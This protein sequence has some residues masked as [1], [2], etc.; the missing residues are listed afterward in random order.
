[1]EGMATKQN[2]EGKENETSVP[3]SQR[4]ASVSEETKPSPTQALG[5]PLL[6]RRV[7]LTGAHTVVVL[8]ALEAPTG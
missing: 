4:H 1:M 7:A 3:P 8:E 6:L 2:N 5:A